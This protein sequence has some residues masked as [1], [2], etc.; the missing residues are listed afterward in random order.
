[1]KL[2]SIRLPL[3]N[4]DTMF[5]GGREVNFAEPKVDTYGWRVLIH[6]QVVTVIVPTLQEERQGG[7]AGGAG[8]WTFARARCVEHWDS[9]DPKDYAKPVQDY[10]S[11]PCGQRVAPE[12]TKAAGGAK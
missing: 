4:Q 6:G 7:R 9:R 8:G 5:R 12:E 3:E 10:E 1:M 11:E 2:L